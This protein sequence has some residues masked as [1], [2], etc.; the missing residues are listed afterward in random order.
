M[1]TEQE[2]H[3]TRIAFMI[4]DGEIK[5]LEY[6]VMSHKEWYESLSLKQEDF[7]NI[8]RGYILDNKAVFYKGNFIY[9]EE[10]IKIAEEF[11][12][13]IK[14]KYN[15]RNLEVWVG[16][17]QGQIGEIWRPIKKIKSFNEE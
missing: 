8:V 5:F 11:S 13:I 16:V 10:V 17:Q 7:N 9:D 1:D 12:T 2:Y 6:S 4:I 14:D 15:I 3:K